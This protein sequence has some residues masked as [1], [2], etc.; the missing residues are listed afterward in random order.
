[1][2]SILKRGFWYLPW[3]ILARVNRSIGLIEEDIVLD[4][5]IPYIWI[6][7]RE[8]K[9]LKTLTSERKIPLVGAALYAFQRLPSGFSH[10]RTA[11]TASTTIN[12]FLR[13]CDLKPTPSHSLY[14][15]RH[16]FKDRLRD[17]GAPEEVIDELMGHKK[18]EP[19]Y[20]RGY[21]LANTYE[22]LKK[23]FFQLPP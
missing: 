20:G 16:T 7:A 6:R 18:L 12:K 15:L 14:S 9:A 11:D 10:Y 23:N 2:A 5:L 17:A 1:M 19:K 3:P 21:M 22:W 13:E 4:E 8:N